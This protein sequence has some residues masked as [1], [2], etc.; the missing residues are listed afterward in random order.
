MV[1]ATPRPINPRERPGIHFRRDCVGPRA[2]LGVCEKSRPHR[3]SIPGPSNL[4]RHYTDWAIPAYLVD[5]YEYPKDW[6]TKSLCKVGN[7]LADYTMSCRRKA[8]L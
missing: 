7:D 4:Y 2:G 5:G 6:C 3:D 1:S 8:S